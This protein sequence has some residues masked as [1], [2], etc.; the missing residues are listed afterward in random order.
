MRSRR[1]LCAAA[2]TGLL[3]AIGAGGGTDTRAAE[4]GPPGPTCRDTA[5]WAAVR[6]CL[7]AATPAASADPAVRP[8]WCPSGWV[9][10]PTAVDAD[11]EAT[12][13]E[14]E[15]RLL[16]A[17]AELAR[18]RHR[19]GA[20]RW[21]AGPGLGVTASSVRDVDANYSWETHFGP[22]VFAGFGLTWGN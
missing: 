21:F 8:P 1:T 10:Q 6:A 11:Q 2:L 22:G 4:T 15:A 19:A 7:G 13:L 12:I 18:L 14:R 3:W 17:T 16:T 20:W 5:S 9:C